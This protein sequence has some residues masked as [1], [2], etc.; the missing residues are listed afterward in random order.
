M[1]WL[2]SACYLVAIVLLATVAHVI[3][4]FG[5]L[6]VQHQALEISPDVVRVVV[7]GYLPL[8]IALGLVHW[9]RRALQARAP[10]SRLAVYTLAL[11]VGY[12]ALVDG[13]WR[14]LIASLN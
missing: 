6:A 4:T 2:E 9:R 14:W 5:L 12:G 11:A 7:I 13:A 3:T 10:R 1:R 8:W